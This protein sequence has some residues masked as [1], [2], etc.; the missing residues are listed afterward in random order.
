MT[1]PNTCGFAD[2]KTATKWF[3]LQAKQAGL[4]PFSAT[5]Y[6]LGPAATD[7]VIEWEDAAQAIQNILQNQMTDGG[8]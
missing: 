5:L 4:N 8:V 7:G 3:I 1:I 2:P 6:L